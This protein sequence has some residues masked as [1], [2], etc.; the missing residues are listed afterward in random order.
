MATANISTS[1][2]PGKTAWD[3]D[4]YT[5]SSKCHNNYSG[6]GIMSSYKYD[7]SQREQSPIDE[8]G[9]YA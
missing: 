1:V 3:H 4:F 6:H 9:G 2:F 7:V 5:R 8:A